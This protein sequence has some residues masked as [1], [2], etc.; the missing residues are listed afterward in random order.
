MAGG[1]LGQAPSACWSKRTA[2]A[3]QRRDGGRRRR[4]AILSFAFVR[5]RRRGSGGLGSVLAGLR[6]V[7]NPQTSLISL[8]GL[9]TN[10]ALL[11]FGGLWGVPFPSDRPRPGASNLWPS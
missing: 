1:V 5:D 11:G 6:Q 10:G 9:G 4:I 7:L 2:G 3:D 8:A